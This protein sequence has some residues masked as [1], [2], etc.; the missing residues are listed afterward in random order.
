MKR[1]HIIL[2][3]IGNVG[4]ALLD[5]LIE[6]QLKLKAE[7]GVE[8]E[9]PIILNSSTAYFPTE[10]LSTNWREEFKKSGTPYR[11]SDII[12]YTHAK[13]FKNLIAIDA[14][15]SSD[16]VL[17][18]EYLIENGFHLIAANK[19]A[20]TKEQ[21]F[22]DN[23]RKQLSIHAK[24]FYYETN[25]GAGLPVVETLSLLHHSGEKINKVR[26]VFSGSLSYLFNVFS[27]EN[28]CFSEVLEQAEKKGYTE[29]DP[30]VDL[31]GTDVARKLLILARELQLRVNLED[32][33]VESLVPSSLNGKTSLQS[34]Q[35][36]ITSLDDTFYGLKQS[37]ASD[38]VLRYIG[39]LDV[40][41]NSLQV[42]LVKA[43]KDSPLGALKGADSLF[44]IYTESYGELPL[45]IQGAGAGAQVTARGIYTDLL[46][47]S[48]HLN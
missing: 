3:G 14:T 25:V 22:Y 28:K 32:V 10:G 35:Q 9:I 27:I 46:K 17:E 39:E 4:S 23:L 37:L 20:N 19:V 47:L 36:R 5:Q 44:E 1:I 24:K 6:T 41:A 43:K 21:S 31:S 13:N 8:I 16:F 26:G 45:V 30:R 34:F 42:K 2:F 18:Y 11:L 7:Y 40:S 12:A 38:E 29:P 15:A 48:G 33:A